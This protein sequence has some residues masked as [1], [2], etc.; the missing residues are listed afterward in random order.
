MCVRGY[1]RVGGATI[2]SMGS[3]C[4]HWVSLPFGVYHHH[5]HPLGVALLIL[6]IARA[7]MCA[8]VF[9]CPPAPAPPRAGRGRGAAETG[10]RTA[11]EHAPFSRAAAFMSLPALE[12]A[13]LRRVL[14]AWILTKGE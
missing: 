11:P 13:R 10:G 7:P 2:G 12:L 5:D 14:G 6:E 3:E 8:P 1:T 9:K 4:A